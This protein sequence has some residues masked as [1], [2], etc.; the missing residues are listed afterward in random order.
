MTITM[1]TLAKD[2]SILRTVSQ[3]VKERTGVIQ[4]TSCTS[5]ELQILLLAVHVRECHKRQD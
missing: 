5:V 2:S 4:I 1:I 3:T